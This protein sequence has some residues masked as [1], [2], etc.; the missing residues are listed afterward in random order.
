M[1]G[2]MKKLLLLISMVFFMTICVYAVETPVNIEITHTGTNVNIS[3]NAVNNANHYKVYTRETPYGQYEWDENGVFPTATSWTKQE[4][5][6]KKFY[7]VTAVQGQAPVFLGT[8]GNFVILAKA[9]ISTIP[10]SA[11]TGNIGISPA[12]ATYMTGFSLMMDPSGTFSTSVQIVGNAY[13]ADYTVP[14]PSNLTVAIGD[15]ESAYV[16]AAG[17]TV[18]DFTNLLSGDIS[19]QTLAPGLYKWSGGVNI[20]TPVTLNGSQNDVWIFQIAQGIDMSPGVNVILSGGAQPKN[21]FWQT[22]GPVS[23]GD[24]AHLEGV[25]L[26]STAISLGVGASVHGRLLAQTAVTLEQSTVT[27]PTP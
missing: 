14:T 2:I 1:E 26:C 22:F 5:S 4:F 15:M 19:G 12:A 27:Q 9:A 11:I 13:A 23:L 6:S 8:A 21:V 17:R 18:P 7:K 10:S 3:W 24:G 25:V 20:S 16:D